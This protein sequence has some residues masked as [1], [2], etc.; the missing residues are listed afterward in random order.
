MK[1]G[2]FLVC[3]YFAEVCINLHLKTAYDSSLMNKIEN[4]CDAR[5]AGCMKTVL[6]QKITQS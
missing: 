6:E 4:A 3:A 1:L 2:G 5:L